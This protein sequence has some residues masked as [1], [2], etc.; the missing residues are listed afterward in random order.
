MPAITFKELKQ[1]WDDG[2]ED[3]RYTINY[4]VNID[5]S[6]KIEP[7]C[8]F[9]EGVKIGKGC[10]IGPYNQFRSGIEI[11]EN[12]HIGGH[13]TFEGKNIHIG[14]NVRVGTHVCIPFNTIIEDNV[15][16]GNGAQL[17]NDK[18]IDWPS[19][20][21]FEPLQTRIC[22]GAKIGVG[23]TLLPGITIGSNSVV[24]AG[25]VVTHSVIQ[26][27]TVYGNPARDVKKEKEEYDKIIKEMNKT[28]RKHEK[29]LGLPPV[30]FD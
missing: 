28:I 14:N 17:S 1:N 4:Y 25:S 13:C 16:L 21:T 20:R 24:G 8:I 9:E 29:L 3:E 12:C 7:Y 6:V 19:T 23:C 2:I 11:G 15:F 22:K 5:D 26:G 27:T 10:I 18:Y 30:K